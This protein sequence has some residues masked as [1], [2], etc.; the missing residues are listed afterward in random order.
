MTSPPFSKDMLTAP[1]QKWRRNHALC[2]RGFFFIR[3]NSPSL[4]YYLH[5][6]QNIQSDSHAQTL[7]RSII[8][9]LENES[10]I[11]FVHAQQPRCQQP[12]CRAMVISPAVAPAQRPLTRPASSRRQI[13]KKVRQAHERCDVKPSNRGG[14]RCQH[15]VVGRYSVPFL[16]WR[17]TKG[18]VT[19]QHGRRNE[20]E[21]VCRGR[22]WW[23]QRR[24]I[25]VPRPG[26]LNITINTAG[27][28]RHHA[29][30]CN[31]RPFSLLRCQR[32]TRGGVSPLTSGA[33]AR[34]QQPLPCPVRVA[35][36]EDNIVKWLFI[37]L[38]IWCRSDI[39]YKS[40]ISRRNK[41]RL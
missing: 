36:C 3:V 31:R 5:V 35:R 2:C 27:H 24:V 34:L 30:H 22:W 10:S 40:F 33:P 38:R 6:P 29:E 11:Y 15:A 39:A 37:I 9:S 20:R 14:R 18:V 19:R 17:C 32:G 25:V 8:G 23:S 13:K 28:W 41:L 26:V 12:L 4:L 1:L 21:I 16:P 7:L